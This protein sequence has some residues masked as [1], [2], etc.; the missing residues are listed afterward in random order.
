MMKMNEEHKAFREMLCRCERTVFKV[1]YMFT[2][3]TPENVK[4]MYQDILYALWESWPLFRHESDVNT[5]VY[6][7]ALNTA[8]A[9]TRR[10]TASPE[11]VPIDS[12]MCETLAEEARNETV[13]QLYRLVDRLDNDEKSLLLLYL[14]RVPAREAGMALGISE[15][16][17]RKRISRI[18][19]KMIK[20]YAD[21]K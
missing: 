2:D 6:R 7:I 19:K 8:L 10:R 4:D 20:L 16:A 21:E 17:F 5:W 11:L 14:D 13:E 12:K 18:K 15:A 1:C 9:Q 3:R